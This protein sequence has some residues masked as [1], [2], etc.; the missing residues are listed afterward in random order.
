MICIKR[1]FHGVIPTIIFVFIII[2]FVFDIFNFLINNYIVFI[3]ILI[4]LIILFLLFLYLFINFLYDLNIRKHGYEIRGIVIEVYI[5]TS[6][7]VA[8]HFVY[9]K[10]KLGNKWIITM[11]NL[12]NRVG[13]KSKRIYFKK[14]DRIPLV[15]NGKKA[16]INYKKL[17]ENSH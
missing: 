5:D 6:G 14:N 4:V 10:Y 11:E 9:Y 12:E 8:K 1:S 15:T 2:L 16:L 13:N 17:Y 7:K 3:I